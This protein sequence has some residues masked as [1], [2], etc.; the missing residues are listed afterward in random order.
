M[1]GQRLKEKNSFDLWK[2]VGS[3]FFLHV[4]LNDYYELIQSIQICVELFRFTS[5]LVAKGKWIE[6]Q[7]TDCKQ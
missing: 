2:F 1:N 4:Q 6:K 5:T 7:T 3:K